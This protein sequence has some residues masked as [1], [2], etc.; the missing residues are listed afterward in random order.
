MSF[1]KPSLLSAC[2]S[3]IWPLNSFNEVTTAHLTKLTADVPKI[4][5]SDN[6]CPPSA[7]IRRTGR[8]LG[9][10]ERLLQSI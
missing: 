6:P 5:K 9:K 7:P 2:R 3:S 10:L 1:M 4:Q 8:L